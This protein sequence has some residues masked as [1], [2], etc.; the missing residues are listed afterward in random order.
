ML[1]TYIG[2]D[3]SEHIDNGDCNIEQSALCLAFILLSKET[4]V[5]T[6]DILWSVP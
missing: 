6:T 2:C 3:G 5:L 1:S 4:C